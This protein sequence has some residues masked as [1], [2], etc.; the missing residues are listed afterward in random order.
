MNTQKSSKVTE[1]KAILTKDK[2]VGHETYPL[3]VKD[4]PAPPPLNLKVHRY[5]IF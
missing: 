1:I 4:K 3:K 5:P 2:I